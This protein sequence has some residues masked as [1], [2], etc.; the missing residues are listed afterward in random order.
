MKANPTRDE[1]K[2]I[3]RAS[4]GTVSKS[5]LAELEKA[6]ASGDSKAAMR[7]E[8]GLAGVLGYYVEDDD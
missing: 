3:A 8:I 4:E 6:E 5:V 1:L 7:A 2:A